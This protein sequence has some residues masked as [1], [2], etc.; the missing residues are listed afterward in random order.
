MA[1]AA[2]PLDRIVRHM[3]LRSIPRLRRPPITISWGLEDGL[4]DE[5]S[6]QA[7]L[8][9]IDPDEENPVVAED[10]DAP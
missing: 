4:L 7:L 8:D 3:I 10:E 6:A 2:P 5:E 1:D 9:E